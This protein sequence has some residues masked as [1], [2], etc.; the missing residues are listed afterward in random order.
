[1]LHVV[2]S[3]VVCEGD[4]SWLP[5]PQHLRRRRHELGVS[6]IGITHHDSIDR[7]L[8]CIESHH[9]HITRRLVLVLMRE[10]IAVISLSGWGILEDIISR[11]AVSPVLW[12]TRRR[13][14]WDN[15]LSDIRVKVEEA[16][17]LFFPT[18]AHIARSRLLLRALITTHHRCL[19]IDI[20]NHRLLQSDR[21]L[22]CYD[23]I[24]K[25]KWIA[26]SPAL[27]LLHCW[28]DL[29][30]ERVSC[31]FACTRLIG[32]LF[33][34][35]LRICVSSNIDCKVEILE[36]LVF[37]RR[38]LS[39][40]SQ[41]RGCCCCFFLGK[42]LLLVLRLVKV[43]TLLIIEKPWIL[44][45]PLLVLKHYNGVGFKGGP[46]AYRR[47]GTWWWRTSSHL[48]GVQSH[49]TRSS[50]WWFWV[51]LAAAGSSKVMPRNFD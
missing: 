17:H 9:R 8:A 34:G 27:G 50:P 35:F 47:L 24:S 39:L 6:G 42:L 16:C 22:T 19:A 1:M 29:K 31:L 48:L 40:D 46:A 45:F 28:L 5:R 23:E 11:W 15:I 51:S 49:L 2:I 12:R 41:W 26:L 20:C 32:T 3:V 21:R 25:S 37:L 14:V 18:T 36:S 33:T 10:I 4:H 30:E 13:R 7:L 43:E 38:F 44:L